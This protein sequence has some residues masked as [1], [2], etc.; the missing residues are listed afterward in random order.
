MKIFIDTNIFLN[1]LLSRRGFEEARE[2]LNACADGVF[3]GFGCDITLLNIDYIAS[4]QT[5]D[6]RDFLKTINE[7]FVVCGVD[8]AMFQEALA[9][10]NGDLEDSV[11]YVCAQS[12]GCAVILTDDRSF[13]QGDIAVSN[14][15]NFVKRYL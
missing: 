3:D 9:I 7:T 4:K 2:I 6:I 13:Y 5:K 8:N 14:S 1:L 10:D 12:N 11:Q 15:E